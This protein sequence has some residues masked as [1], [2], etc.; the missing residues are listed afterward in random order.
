[1][2]DLPLR[3][4]LL[5]GWATGEMSSS[6]VLEIASGAAQQGATGLADMSSLGS[7]NA[8]RSLQAVFGYPVGAPHMTWLEIPTTAGP[9]TPH[10]FLL[11]HEFFSSY[12]THR[13]KDWTSTMARSGEAC[14]EFWQGMSQSAFVKKHPSLPRSSWGSTIPIGFHGDAGAY[15]NHDSLYTIS[16]NSLIGSGKTAEKRFVFTVLRKAEMTADTLDFVFRTL[17]WSLNSMLCGDSP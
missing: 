6:K 16:W 15:S 9:R 4:T 2:D 7:H 17:G 3:K 14:F 5:K 12:F 8:F 1:M 11:P 13:K 10:P